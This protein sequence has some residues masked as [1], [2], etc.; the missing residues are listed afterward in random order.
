MKDIF[1]KNIVY[2]A[3][4]LIASLNCEKKKKTLA[5]SRLNFFNL[6]ST[7]AIKWPWPLTL[8]MNKFLQIWSFY[9]WLMGEIGW[10][11]KFPFILS[12]AM[13]YIRLLTTPWNS[14]SWISR[15]LFEYNYLNMRDSM[16]DKKYRNQIG[17]KMCNFR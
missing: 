17:E 9:S 13:L 2:H 11:V 8:K 15:K 3:Y 10:Y 6:I 7:K 1:F 4:S 12:L 16:M 5:V 14:F